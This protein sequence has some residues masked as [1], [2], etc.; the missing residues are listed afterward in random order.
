MH[1]AAA[2]ALYFSVIKFREKRIDKNVIVV[3]LTV[4]SNITTFLSM[5]IFES[6]VVMATKQK[7]PDFPNR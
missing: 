1:F 2:F 6:I 7:R 5:R 4:W 3:K